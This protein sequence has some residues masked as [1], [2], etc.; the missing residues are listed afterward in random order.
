MQN[1]AF[2]R[3]DLKGLIIQINKLDVSVKPSKF[4]NV[5]DE[6]FIKPSILFDQQNK[7]DLTNHEE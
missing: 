4:P 3:K 2:W 5:S 1:K 6:P 7:K